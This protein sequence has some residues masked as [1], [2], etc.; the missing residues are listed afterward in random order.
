MG[1]HDQRR[2]DRFR[3]VS[4]LLIGSARCFFGAAMLPKSGLGLR[5]TPA[6]SRRLTEAD[7]DRF[8]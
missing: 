5:E 6:M 8:R 2:L 7:A 1:R 3:G 4:P